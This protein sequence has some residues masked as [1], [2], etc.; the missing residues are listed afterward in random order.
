[1]LGRCRGAKSIDAGKYWNAGYEFGSWAEFREWSLAN[2]YRKGVQLDRIYG[3]LPYSP[4]NCQWLTAS[5]HGR[6]S[7]TSAN[8][9]RKKAN[10]E[11]EAWLHD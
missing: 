8:M 1:M 6:K 3:W 4:S 11:P 5:E 9:K 2:G 10:S 7:A